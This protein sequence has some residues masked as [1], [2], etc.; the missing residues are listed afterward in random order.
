VTAADVVQEAHTD[1]TALAGKVALVT[2]GASG[3]GRAMA[4]ALAHA[5]ARVVVADL[6]ARAGREVADLAGGT[7]RACDVSDLDANR[8]PTG[9]WWT[10]PRRCTAVSTSRCSTRA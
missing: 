3:L 10:S 2:G 6:D 9:R 5:G 4:L 8:T 1:G 7:F